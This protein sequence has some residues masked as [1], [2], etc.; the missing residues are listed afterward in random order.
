MQDP[1]PTPD[2]GHSEPTREG[3]P[4]EFDA[5]TRA[6][7]TAGPPQPTAI[8]KRFGR[9][10]IIDV[11]GSGGMGTVFEARDTTLDR[12]VALKLLHASVAPKPQRRLLREAKALAKLSHPNVVQ[13]FEA[14]LVEGRAFIAMELVRGQDLA[15][16]QRERHGWRECVEIYLQAARGLAAA[17]EEGLL[18][19]DFKPGNCIIDES[20]RVRVLDFGLARPIH[21]LRHASRTTA[22]E[23]A[24]SDGAQRIVEGRRR[25]VIGTLGYMPLEQL[26]RQP[27]DA[28]SDQ[29]S[30]CVSLFE[31]LHGQRPFSGSDIDDLIGRMLDGSIDDPPSKQRIPR[32]L[33]RLLERGLGARPQHRWDS[34]EEFIEELESTL[35]P[36]R[37]RWWWGAAGLGVL[38]LSTG[39]WWSLR[40][41]PCDDPS[42]ALG[43]AWNEAQRARVSEALADTDEG[44][45]L[46]IPAR[47]DEH[48]EHWMQ[49]Q[50]ELCAAE[51]DPASDPVKRTTHQTC[52]DEGRESLVQTVDLLLESEPE[53][54]LIAARRLQLPDLSRCSDPERF[55]SYLPLPDDPDDAARARPL[56]LVLARCDLLIGSGRYDD[57]LELLRSAI[58]EAEDLGFGPLLAEVELK[59]GTILSNQGQYEQANQHLEE[60]YARALE[61]GYAH[62]ELLASNALAY[63]VG[64][65]LDQHEAG[66]KWGLT[67]EARARQPWVAANVRHTTIEL[68]G[69]IYYEQGRFS[70]A[71][72]R[73]E[74]ALAAR[75]ASNPDDPGLDL[76][77]ANIALV[78]HEQGRYEDALPVLRDV[79]EVKLD[80]LG[81][82]HPSVAHARLRLGMTL[83]RLGQHDAAMDLYTASLESY[84]A[85]HGLVHP[86]SAAVLVE[87]GRLLVDRGEWADALAIH[88][89]AL[90]VSEQA[91]GPSH[92]H[93][94]ECWLG[95]GRVLTAYGQLEP[96]R[97][98]VERGVRIVEQ[99]LG[100]RH[101]YTGAALTQLGALQL[102]RGERAEARDTL[103]R[104][105][106]I[107]EESEGPA[108]TTAQAR[109]ALAQV[110]WSSPGERDD[111]L[112]F[113]RRAR[114]TFAEVAS[115]DPEPLAA[116]DAWLEHAQRPAPALPIDPPP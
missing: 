74:R 47:L 71:L 112:S 14:G 58:P 50:R 43:T 16:W 55:E 52:L 56:R 45:A 92:S 10:E 75:E 44:L 80:R 18:H 65:L 103:E 36:P 48:A 60:A 61:H 2:E 19:R 96:A 12:T 100:P 54:R 83:H 51:R 7:G 77:R 17:H 87:I 57:A 116:L 109:F 22:S 88:Q 94:A 1:N 79:L 53:L 5:Q 39:V 63:V 29:F 95:L 25:G 30:L 89:H 99:A 38:G 78:L 111:A 23:D 76:T 85:S 108:T 4:L 115:A 11:L 73:Y 86:G 40:P 20:G 24:M 9:F 113:A 72:E 62:T 114:Q 49:S 91:F 41:S 84:Q 26:W 46:S 97:R 105:L 104:A 21:R 33:Q 93:V 70:S 6:E 68:V 31:A 64:D 27:L 8:E 69:N 32:A 81:T 66:L 3:E 82:D 35:T 59:H 90:W 98:H 28:K 67:A 34:M 102:Q 107:L 106:G 101:V 13:I 37:R 42:E 15:R 110:L